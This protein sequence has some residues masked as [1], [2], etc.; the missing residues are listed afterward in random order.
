MFTGRE[1]DSETGLY[2]YRARYYKPSIGRFLQTDP[3]GY[4]DSM[5]LY[6]YC[7]NNPVNFVDPW[8]EASI[9]TAPVKN[10][11]LGPIAR[12]IYG[13]TRYSG[14]WQIL[15]N[16]G[17]NSGYFGGSSWFGLGGTPVFG[18]DRNRTARDYKTFLNNLD[19]EL[20]RRAER[21]IQNRW[22]NEGRRYHPLDNSCQTYILDVLREY[23][24]L[25]KEQEREKKC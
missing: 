9:G 18:T 23:R 25:E 21:N 8:G 5:N 16:D 15:Y 22:Q 3:I 4:Y 20:L 13:N 17:S 24:K 14:H 19:D 1:Y 6:Q 2:Y 10:P 11:V 7:G 12:E